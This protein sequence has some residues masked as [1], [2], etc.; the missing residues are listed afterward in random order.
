MIKNFIE[1]YKQFISNITDA[2]KEFIEASAIFLISTMCQRN[3]VVISKADA[4]L[5]DEKE[6]G[7]H[8]NLWFMF[9]GKSR[10]SRKSTTIAKAQELIGAIDNLLLLPDDFTP[11]SLITEL[12]AKINEHMETPATWIHDEISGFFDILNRKESYMASTEAVLSKLYD[13]RSYRKTTITRGKEDIPKPY[14]TILVASTE[15]LPTIFDKRSIKQ[16]FL[17]RF[18]FIPAKRK[19][20][21]LLQT[22]FYTMQERAKIKEIVDWLTELYHRTEITI[23]SFNSEALNLYNQFELAIENEIESKDLGLTEGFIGNLPNIVTRLSAIFRISRM[24]TSEI[25]SYHMPILLMEEE[26]MKKAVEYANI[27]KEWFKKTIELMQLKTTEIPARTEEASFQLVL[28]ILQRHTTVYK[29]KDNNKSIK[30]MTYTDLLRESK[31]MKMQLDK[32]LE[33]LHSRGDIWY[34]LV[35]IERKGGRVP[36][37]VML[38][39]KKKLI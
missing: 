9:L 39:P 4:S 25:A 31:L 14:L 13:C 1:E 5:L 24:S 19:E 2:P 12:H 38:M 36:V 10:V 11:Q 15:D 18:I 16:G 30:A 6:F 20:K 22:S 37:L 34:G 26:D 23:L 17:N 27:S 21:R 28:G 29:R 35:D 8:L 32:V 7:R 3:F 33:T